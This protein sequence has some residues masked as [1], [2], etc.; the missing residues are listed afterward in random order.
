M[1]FEGSI[2][3]PAQITADQNNYDLGGTAARLYRLSTDTA[4][5][6]TGIAAPGG[7]NAVKEILISNVGA[8]DLKIA[9]ES[10]SSTAANRVITGTGGEITL[11][12]GSPPIALYYDT[13]SS[14]WR[15]M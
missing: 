3:T 11:A 14:R 4:R 15:V 5:T 1:P 9:D 6:I 10:A 7:N 8:N 12:S 13:T 2:Q